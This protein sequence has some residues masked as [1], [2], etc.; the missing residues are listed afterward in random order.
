MK[1][2]LILNGFMMTI[3]GVQGFYKLLAKIKAK[4]I[5]KFMINDDYSEIADKVRVKNVMITENGK[6]ATEKYNIMVAD[7]GFVTASREKP[8][9]LSAG[10]AIMKITF[11]V[12]D[13][14]LKKQADTATLV[15]T[16][17][18]PEQPK[19]QK[20]KLLMSGLVTLGVLMIIAGF[21]M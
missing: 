2:A 10:N 19:Y 21:L 16:I 3:I 18:I 20:Q 7:Q 6:V 12:T 5:A 15:V 17:P 14:D 4:T 1:I 9:T 13:Q 11:D 8:S